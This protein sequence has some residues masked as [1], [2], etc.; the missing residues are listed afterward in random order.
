MYLQSPDGEMAGNYPGG[1]IG[2][3][4][5]AVLI[6]QVLSSEILGNLHVPRFANGRE[7]IDS[8]N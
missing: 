2:G 5:V 3:L 4:D 8:D 1:G 7:I 6:R